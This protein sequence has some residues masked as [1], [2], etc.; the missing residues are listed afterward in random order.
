[1]PSQQGIERLDAATVRERFAS[2]AFAIAED[3]GTIS[4][5]LASAHARGTTLLIE[6]ELGAG[7][8]DIAELVYLQGP[9]SSEPLV[10]VTVPALSERSWRHLVRGVDSPLYQ[11]G[12]TVIIE[13]VN[14]LDARRANELASSLSTAVASKGCRL[15]LTGD[16]VPGG[17]EAPATTLLADRLGCAVSIAPALRDQESVSRK[18]VRYLAFLSE[19]FGTGAPAV[20]GQAAR[21]LDDYAWPRNYM[22]LREV[23]ERLYI[24]VGEGVIDADVVGEVLGQ[25]AVIKTATFNAPTLDSDLFI[26]RPL[27]DTERDI[28]R[29]VVEHL[30]GNKTRAAEI[31]GISRTTL[32]RLLKE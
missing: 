1:M 30:G 8:L 5:A 29:M 10:E 31:L 18:L 2:G 22:Q 20:D 21:M 12:L 19:S 27:A 6:G 15:I 4:P 9:Y 17:G 13:G 14:T 24:S 26:L 32:W 11:V 23:A 25:E 7:S 3:G 28:A 16:E